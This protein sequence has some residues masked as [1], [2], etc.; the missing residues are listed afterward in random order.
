MQPF[1]HITKTH[2]HHRQAIDVN[3]NCAPAPPLP[4]TT[5][6][7]K[8]S[9]SK[10]PKNIADIPKYRDPTTGAIWTGKGK[11]PA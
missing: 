5:R 7:R 3:K 10:L 2:N 1:S 4:K 8:A 6:G 9:A 11:P